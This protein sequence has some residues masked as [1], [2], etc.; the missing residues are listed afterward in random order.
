MKNLVTVVKEVVDGVEIYMLE[1]P[2]FVQV[3]NVLAS[4]I[5][6]HMRYPE[7]T[8]EVPNVCLEWKLSIRQLTDTRHARCCGHLHDWICEASMVWLAKTDAGEVAIPLHTIRFKVFADGS[9]CWHGARVE[10]F[11][12]E[13]MPSIVEMA[14][15]LSF[16]DIE[17]P[18]KPGK[19]LYF[20]RNW[21]PRI[22][23]PQAK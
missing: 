4:C 15:A 2:K 9:F 13:D 20:K 5:E 14:Q 12:G 23:K 22:I 10:I 7:T 6:K 17:K 18:G 21:L 16:G 3:W 1:I 19:K 11:T 8:S